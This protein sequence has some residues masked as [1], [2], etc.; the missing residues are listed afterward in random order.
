MRLRFGEPG[1]PQIDKTKINFLLCLQQCLTYNYYFS[2]GSTGGYHKLQNQQKLSRLQLRYL[3]LLFLFNCIT[4][5]RRA[6]T[7]LMSRNAGFH[8]TSTDADKTFKLFFFLNM[9][10]RQIEVML[11]TKS[12]GQDVRQ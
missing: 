10:F 2:S 4:P 9:N 5:R 3:L 8:S 12:T 7:S 11:W 1:P 6:Y